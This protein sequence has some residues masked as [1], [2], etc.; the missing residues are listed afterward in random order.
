MA[1]RL[2]WLI[3]PAYQNPTISNYLCD[4]ALTRR[5][6]CFHQCKLTG[7]IR[8][9]TK[10]MQLIRRL[11]QLLLGKQYLIYLR[12]N[13]SAVSRSG[14]YEQ[15][16]NTELSTN[17]V[18]LHQRHIPANSPS[19]VR[20]LRHFRL[21]SISVRGDRN[22]RHLSIGFFSFFFRFPAIISYF[23]VIIPISVVGKKQRWRL[24]EVGRHV[25]EIQMQEK[26]R[27]RTRPTLTPIG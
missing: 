18:L 25:Q 3:T 19:L 9:I 4:D 10:V 7:I 6:C 16:V 24:D 23:P 17:Q 8:Y 2:R 13:S 12:Q 1:D 22:L 21:A 5:R 27:T 14:P 15:A 26:R 11:W 20:S